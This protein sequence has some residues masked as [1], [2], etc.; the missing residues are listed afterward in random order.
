MA[1]NQLLHQKKSPKITFLVV[2]NFFLVQKLIF[3]AIFWNSKKVFF[4]FWK[5]HFFLNLDSTVILPGLELLM[6]IFAA[7]P[8]DICDELR[9]DNEALTGLW[10]CWL[11]GLRADAVDGGGAEPKGGGTTKLDDEFI[12]KVLSQ[13]AELYEELV[14]PLWLGETWWGPGGDRVIWNIY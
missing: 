5:L 3:F 2:L 12:R 11:V 10:W 14:F 9:L 8:D 13:V 6:T 1:K 7:S 4:Y